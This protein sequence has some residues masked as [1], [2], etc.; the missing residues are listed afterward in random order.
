MGDTHCDGGQITAEGKQQRCRR[1]ERHRHYEDQDQCEAHNR[2]IS[3]GSGRI[4][5]HSANVFVEGPEA[6]YCKREIGPEKE[7]FCSPIPAPV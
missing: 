1:K 6:A 2:W 4:K 5:K 7:D 3:R